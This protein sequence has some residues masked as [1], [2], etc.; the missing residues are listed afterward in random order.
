LTSLFEYPDNENDDGL[1]DDEK[2]TMQVRAPFLDGVD[3]GE[4]LLFMHRIIRFGA[5]EFPRCKGDWMGSMLAF[6]L[7]YCADSNVTRVAR[8][9][10]RF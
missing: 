1:Y 7:Q 8:Y 2:T 6:L 10:V 5:E 9:N 4:Q 3:N